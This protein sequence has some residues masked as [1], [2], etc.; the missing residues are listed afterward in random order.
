M[1]VRIKADERIGRIGSDPYITV[2]LERVAVLDPGL[3][4]VVEREVEHVRL[5][6]GFSNPT[7]HRLHPRHLDTLIDLLHRTRERLLDSDEAVLGDP[8]GRPEASRSCT[9]TSCVADDLDEADRLG[10]KSV[11]AVDDAEAVGTDA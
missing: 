4:E 3:S 7:A 10:A 1:S 9:R 6:I 8:L 11:L 5:E 2:Y